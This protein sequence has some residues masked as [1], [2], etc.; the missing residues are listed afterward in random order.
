MLTHL[1]L[2]RHCQ[3]HPSPEL[4]DCD[5]PLSER[6]RRQ[7]RDLVAVLAPLNA[8]LVCSSPFKRC[9]DTIAP[10]AASLELAVETD[11]GLRERRIAAG[12]V[13][14]FRDFWRR[15]WEDLSY[16]LEGGETSLECRTRLVAAVDSIVRRHEGKRVLVG[17]H[18]CALALFLSAFTPGYGI[19]E[20][21]AMR[22]PELLHVTHD[23]RYGYRWQRDF[24]PPA[25]FESLATAYS[26]TPGVLA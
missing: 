11:A 5:Y 17:S 22:T 10:A 6:G 13:G 26:E 25:G 16:A 8:E 12:W 9:L 19:V 18:G 20:A 23:S 2:L 24:L 3:S 7:A 4:S 15:S 1:F 14:D 21:S